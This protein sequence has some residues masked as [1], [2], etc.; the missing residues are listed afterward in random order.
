MFIH[1]IFYFSDPTLHC[2]NLMHPYCGEVIAQRESHIGSRAVFYC[3]A[4][5]SSDPNRYFAICRSP[6]IWWLP[7]QDCREYKY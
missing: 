5:G 7:I 2:E 1:F 4:Q 3:F 6:G